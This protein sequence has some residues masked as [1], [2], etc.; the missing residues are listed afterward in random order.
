MAAKRGHLARLFLLCWGC[1]SG[2]AKAV[3]MQ[4]KCAVVVK[5]Q[6]WLAED[7]EGEKQAN[8]DYKVRVEPWTL[9]GKV[10]VDLIGKR[11]SVEH[12]Y[13]GTTESLGRSTFTV[14]LSAVPVGGE[15]AF[16]ISGYG[17]PI[18]L[19]ELSCFDLHKVRPYRSPIMMHTAST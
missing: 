17:E 3:D 15:S 10:R 16:E 13:G 12:V 2:H 1:A 7:M 19:P 4:G 9:F 5:E 18:R 11:M 6:K 8:W 14:T